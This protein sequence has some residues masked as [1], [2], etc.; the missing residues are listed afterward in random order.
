MEELNPAEGPDMIHYCVIYPA[1]D[2][3]LIIISFIA[4]KQ[5]KS[6]SYALITDSEFKEYQ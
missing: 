3:L 4:I 1:V 5:V 6:R 2:A